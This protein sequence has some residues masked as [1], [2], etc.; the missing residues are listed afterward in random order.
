MFI[1]SVTVTHLLLL[2]LY[3]EMRGNAGSVYS[4]GICPW[5]LPL[6][7]LSLADTVF[8]FSAF[9]YPGMWD[10]P[11]PMFPGSHSPCCRD[12]N[13]VTSQQRRLPAAEP[14]SRK[15]M[16]TELIKSGFGPR[17]S[18]V[19]LDMMW[20][21]SQGPQLRTCV[22]TA[23]E[24]PKGARRLVSRGYSGC[25]CEILHTVWKPS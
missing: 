6:L 13:G 22:G 14:R 5:S 25:L 3:L 23:H 15:R 19:R 7:I 8:L 18:S 12:C 21:V 11:M 9:S 1:I 20:L 16:S 10:M 17:Q 24:D 4:L 2:G